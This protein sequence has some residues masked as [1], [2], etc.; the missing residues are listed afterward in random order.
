MFSLLTGCAHVKAHSH[1]H[2]SRLCVTML[3][4][5]AVS[6]CTFLVAQ[7]AD[8]QIVVISNQVWHDESATTSGCN[9]LDAY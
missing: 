2:T 6:L 4:A 5:A 8:P 3:A 7:D 1:S 9:L